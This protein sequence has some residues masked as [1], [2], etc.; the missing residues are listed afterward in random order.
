MARR[1]SQRLPD[2]AA[3]VTPAANPPASP[4]PTS[5]PVP[6]GFSPLSPRSLWPREQFRRRRLR[7]LRPSLPRRGGRPPLYGSFQRIREKQVSA[8][9]GFFSVRG[10]R[11]SHSHIFYFV[12]IV[13]MHFAYFDKGALRGI[14]ERGR[15]GDFRPLP[16]LLRFS[17]VEI[18]IIL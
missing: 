17:F 12:E 11:F 9:C 16:P 4:S 2:L 7:P 10:F 6:L 13:E 3:V 15:G 14:E 5:P 1:F 18:V 8:R